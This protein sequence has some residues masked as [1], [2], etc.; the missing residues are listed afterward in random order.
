M[1]SHGGRAGW[2]CRSPLA[3]LRRWPGSVTTALGQLR[4]QTLQPPRPPGPALG[5][6]YQ[7]HVLEPSLHKHAH[8]G[9]MS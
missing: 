9:S 7:L 8:P 2:I 6:R 4:A 3:F 1:R 5:E